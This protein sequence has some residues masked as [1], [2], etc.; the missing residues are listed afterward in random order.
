MVLAIDAPLDNLFL[1][2][3]PMRNSDWKPWNPTRGVSDL[4]SPPCP[5]LLN[6]RGQSPTLAHPLQAASVRLERHDQHRLQLHED[7]G[8]LPRIGTWMHRPAS[9]LLSPGWT[10][11]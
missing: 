2:W 1:K 8:I 7:R 11:S 4:S 6:R 5:G 3:L 10:S 9:M